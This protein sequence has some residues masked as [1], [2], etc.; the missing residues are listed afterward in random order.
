MAHRYHPISLI[1]E[2]KAEDPGRGEEQQ[3]IA[4]LSKIFGETP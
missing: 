2:R 3:V 4:A 1:E